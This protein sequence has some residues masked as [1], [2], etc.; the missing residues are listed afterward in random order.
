MTDA[1]DPTPAPHYKEPGWFT[2]NV[3]NRTV[4]RADPPR[5]QRVGQPRARGPGPQDR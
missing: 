3:F 1:N 5:H 4:V 2:R